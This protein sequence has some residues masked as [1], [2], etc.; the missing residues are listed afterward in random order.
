MLGGNLSKSQKSQ[1]E[2]ET[3]K[4]EGE[5]KVFSNCQGRGN[6]HAYGRA[7]TFEGRK[8]SRKFVKKPTHVWK[9]RKR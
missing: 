2:G 5:S 1:K 8:N 4:S 3:S 6:T 7:S 9:G